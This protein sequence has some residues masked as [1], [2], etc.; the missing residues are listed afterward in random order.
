M[1]PLRI[2]V[3]ALYLIPGGVGGTEIYLRQLLLALSGID[4]HNQYFI[5]TNRET[6]A[7]LAPPQPNFHLVPQAVRA[8]SRPARILWEQTMLPLAIARHR[9]DVL[10]N[11]GF[12]A[13]LFSGCPAVTVFHDVQ[14]K[15]HPEHFRWFDLPFWRM[16]LYV[17]AHRAA[18]VLASSDA[19]RDDVLRY[20]R[21]P[22]SQV[23]VTR[24]GV[25]QAFFGMPRAPEKFL[26]TVSTLHPHKGLEFLLRAFAKFHQAQPEYRLIIAGLRGFH[27][28]PLERLRLELGLAGVVEFTGWIP[29]E[30]LYDLYSRASAFLYP[31][32]FEGFGIPVVEALAAGIPTACSNIEPLAGIAGD[33][34]LKFEPGNVDAIYAAMLRLTSDDALRARLATDGPRRA[35]AFSWTATARAT[36]DAFEEVCKNSG[37]R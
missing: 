24:L 14:H 2:G 6:G 28:E 25:D 11:P 7:D 5:F 21:L 26:L 8:T 10:L 29:R 4:R 1:Q 22:C 19:T 17:S 27:S 23:R 15:R 30:Q 34:A 32:T 12:T 9:L 31:S 13:P 37:A 35:A 18:L 20:Y 16:L 33:A 36:L 3:N